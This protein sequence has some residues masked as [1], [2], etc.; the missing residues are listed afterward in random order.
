MLTRIDKLTSF[1]DTYSPLPK[2][3]VISLDADFAIRYN[4][5]S[6]RIEGNTL[7]LVEARVFLEMESL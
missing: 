4:H 7:T 5:E 2:D 3:T 1:L 6:N